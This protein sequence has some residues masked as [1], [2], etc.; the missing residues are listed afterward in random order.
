MIT[1]SHAFINKKTGMIHLRNHTSFLI[2]TV[3]H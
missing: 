2:G 3:F 1:L